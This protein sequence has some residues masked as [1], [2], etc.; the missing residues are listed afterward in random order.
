MTF[1]PI[2]E[3]AAR[4]FLRALFGKCYR[5]PAGLTWYEV[6]CLQWMPEHKNVWLV[7]GAEGLVG[8]YGVEKR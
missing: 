2:T 6:R 8:V 7:A 1:Q 5:V 4:R 3:R